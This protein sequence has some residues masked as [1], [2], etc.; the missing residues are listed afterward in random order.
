MNI[1]VSLWLAWFSTYPTYTSDKTWSFVK[2]FNK[3][4]WHLTFQIFSSLPLS[5]LMPVHPVIMIHWRG[6]LHRF[7]PL[8][9][10][11]LWTREIRM[12]VVVFNHIVFC[13]PIC[14]SHPFLWGFGSYW[15]SY[16][17]MYL[18]PTNFDL[19]ILVFGEIAQLFHAILMNL[20]SQCYPYVILHY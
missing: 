19:I 13:M 12:D 8:T 11:L 5:I 20:P 1:E 4:N 18:R 14:T 16:F 7:I 17:S 3:L 15:A 9:D 2:N 6:S 10:Q